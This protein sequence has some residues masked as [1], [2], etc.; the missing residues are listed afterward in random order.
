MRVITHWMRSLAVVMA[1][2]IASSL[3]A[4]MIN[5][6]TESFENG[7]S[8]PTGWA[9]ETVSGS[10]ALSFVTSGTYPTI[11]AAPNGTYMVKFASWSYSTATNRLKKTT[12]FSTVGKQNVTVNFKWSEDVGYPSSA[13]KVVVEWSTNG[14]TW[15]D[16]G[17]FNR[18]NATAGW[19]DKSVVLPAGA[20]NVPALYVAFRF[21][22]AYGNNCYL[23]LVKVD[24]ENIPTAATLAGTVTN[25]ITGLPII[26]AMVNINDSITYTDFAGHYTLTAN[27]GTRPVLVSKLGFDNYSSTVVIAG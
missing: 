26:G 16:A 14:T 2:F 24:A 27:N 13:D 7:G 5:L 19:K 25:G 18:Y 21:I 3:N 9:T 1:V 17:S 6:V 22:S 15:T 12:S 4:Q 10:S 11:A 20:G 8:V 23:D